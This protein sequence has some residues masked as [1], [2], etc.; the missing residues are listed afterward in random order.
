[1]KTQWA[2]ALA[3]LVWRLSGGGAGPGVME[4]TAA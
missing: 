4:A 1:M 3:L 2:P